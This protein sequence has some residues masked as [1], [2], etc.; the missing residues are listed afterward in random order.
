MDIVCI[1]DTHGK[2]RDL[3]L[4]DGDLLIHA[5]DFSNRGDLAEVNSFLTWFG[6]Q[7]HPHKVL[8][9]GNHDFIAER[10]PGLFKSMIPEN[11]VY[12]Q[13]SGAEVAG[14]RFWGSPVT[15]WFYD[16]AFN[17]YEDEI[18]WHWDMIPQDTQILVTHGPPL[19]T[20]DMNFQGTP[21][22]CKSLGECVDELPELRYHIFGHIHEAYGQYER[23]G[24]SLVNASQ[25]DLKYQLAQA[26]IVIRWE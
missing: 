23:S 9:A 4:P 10:D 2:H 26:P 6:A 21:V 25:V 22:G 12:L 20:G 24:K 18:V 15:P 8:I 1:S 7:P 17:R 14:I 3:V 5:G 11:V 19:G 16:W 13:D